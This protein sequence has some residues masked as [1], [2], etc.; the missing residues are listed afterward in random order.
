MTEKVQDQ[1]KV[2]KLTKVLKDLEVKYQNFKKDRIELLK[3]AE[4]VLP[5]SEEAAAQAKAEPGKVDCEVL[6]KLFKATE[7]Q[8]NKL[9]EELETLRNNEKLMQERLS[10]IE[11]QTKQQ[12]KEEGNALLAKI[13]SIGSSNQLPAVNN[14]SLVESLEEKIRSQEKL[15][16]SLKSQLLPSKAPSIIPKLE[17]REVGIQV[18]SATPQTAEDS[19]LLKGEILELRRA[20]EVLQHEHN[21]T[22]Q[23]AS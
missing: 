17:I 23:T 15:I 20:L 9:K 3:F 11:T 16:S 4:T 7:I 12:V 18:G 6:V 19:E 14:S 13:K 10:Q 5:P 2:Q 1:T 8:N 22:L 21:V